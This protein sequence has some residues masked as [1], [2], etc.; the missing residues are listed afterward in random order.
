MLWVKVWERMLGPAIALQQARACTADAT[1][2]G[3]QRVASPDSMRKGSREI[4]PCI[5]RQAAR[6]KLNTQAVTI[7]MC[8]TDNYVYPMCASLSIQ[9]WLWTD[10]DI[11][12]IVLKIKALI[13]SYSLSQRKLDERQAF[14]FRRSRMLCGL[15]VSVFFW[16]TQVKVIVSRLMDRWMFLASQYRKHPLE[17]QMHWALGPWGILLRHT[18]VWLL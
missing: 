16:S 4:S 18:R 11:L 17:I 6:R 8:L 5:Q 15:L 1:P 7:N 2:T 13:L 12:Y 3:T 10:K 9:E 14:E